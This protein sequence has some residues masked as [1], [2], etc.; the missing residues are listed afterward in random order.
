V[1][2]TKNPELAKIGIGETG[3]PSLNNAD[4]A[5]QTSTD[6]E[7]IH[8]SGATHPPA[9]ADHPILIVVKGLDSGRIV[10]IGRGEVTIGR[11]RDC[12][13]VV[14]D[15]GVS[16]HHAKLSLTNPD[17][18]GEMLRDGAFVLEDLQSKNGTFVAGTQV[19]KPHEI[20]YGDTFQIGPD[21][22]IRLGRMTAAEDRAARHLYASSMRDALTNVF[23][24]RYFA[25]RLHSEL[26]HSKR[27][28]V[29]VSVLVLNIDQFK[30]INDAHGHTTGDAVMQAFVRA[31]QR[32]LRA[33]DV[34]ARVESQDF[35]II[36]RGLDETGAIACAERLRAL[37]AKEELPIP[38]PSTIT[39]SA[40]IA[41]SRDES[42]NILDLASSRL[43]LAKS[44]GRN[45]ICWT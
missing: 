19:K 6:T 33:E 4:H 7:T 30:Q 17:T 39:A 43:R 13:L 28:G 2:A 27:H 21:V 45:Q 22:I 16:G 38:E 15:R 32:D 5:E 23:N 25:Q 34:L 41:T 24:R 9:V 29:P 10:S 1:S 42:E 35:A 20:A 40:G 3:L 12:V 8:V 11:A 18:A 14:T 36:L 37:V 44:L 26:A 31:L